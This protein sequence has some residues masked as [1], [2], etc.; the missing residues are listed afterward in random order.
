MDVYEYIKKKNNKKNNKL[1][2]KFSN[3]LTKILITIIFVFV[4]IIYVK[5]SD[6]NLKLY[7]KNVFE[8]TISF[9]RANQFLS[10]FLGTKKKIPLIKDAYVFN[11]ANKTQEKFLNGTKITYTSITPIKALESGVVVFIGEKD[12]LGKTIIIQ[13]TDEYDIWYSN[14]S[15]FNLNMYDYIEKDSI[16]GNS[17]EV[18]ITISKNG[19]FIDYEKYQ[20][21]A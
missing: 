6:D 2:D 18:I 7:K 11:E 10:K 5:K 16:I 17:N 19:N 13:G 12:N 14:V 1:S 3:V 15:D 8:T 20:N 4:S 21:K 9:N